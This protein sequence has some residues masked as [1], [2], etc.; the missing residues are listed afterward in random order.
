MEIENGDFVS[1][2][3]HPLKYQTGKYVGTGTQ[4]PY[5]FRDWDYDG[6]GV[7]KMRNGAGV[8]GESYQ[9]H[10]YPPVGTYGDSKV[11]VNVFLW[12]NMWSKPVFTLDGGAPVEMTP[13]ESTSRYDFADT[14]FKT[15]YKTYNST[16]AGDSGYKASTTASPN[17]LFS[18]PVGATTGS[19]TVSVTDRFGNVYTGKVSW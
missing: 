16:M 18:T 4:P 8:L 9:M 11:Y 12:D 13:V 5:V 17:T 10:V 15:F 3:F 14:E 6:D 1:W 7:A 19:G 2:R